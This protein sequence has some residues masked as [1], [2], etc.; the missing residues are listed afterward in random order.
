MANY[1]CVRNENGRH[2]TVW[3]RVRQIVR[4]VFN[5]ISNVNKLITHIVCDKF[6]IK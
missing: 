4:N 6:V 2:G 5:S 3:R 1:K